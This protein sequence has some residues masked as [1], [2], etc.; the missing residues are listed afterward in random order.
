[1]D[2]NKFMAEY[3]RLCDS[4]TI[5]ADCPLNTDRPCAEIPSCY[6]NEFTTKLIK[7]VEDWSSAHPVP[8]RAHLFKKIFPNARTNK[9]GSLRLCPH[10]LDESFN[11]QRELNCIQC[12]TLYWLKE[13]QQ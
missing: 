8:T 1:M 12:R 10:D 9:D 11:C 5:C 4:Y 6:T 13:V 2:A 3:K 7:V